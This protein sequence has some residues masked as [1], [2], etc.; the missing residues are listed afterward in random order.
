ME[1]IK[2]YSNLWEE[3]NENYSDPRTSD[4][5]MMDSPIPSTLICLGYL[6]VVWMGPTFMANRPAYNIRQLLLV[7]NVFMVALSGYLF[8]E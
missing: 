2:Y 8:Y 4:L 6:I 5:F 7:Y 1:T 3:T